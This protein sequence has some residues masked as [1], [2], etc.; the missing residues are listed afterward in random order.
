MFLDIDMID[1]E[2][3]YF[4][5]K[6]EEVVGKFFEE[7]KEELKEE[8]KIEELKEELKEVILEDVLNIE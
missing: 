5:E 7:E 4:F 8:E 6:D 1:V 3:E 2:V